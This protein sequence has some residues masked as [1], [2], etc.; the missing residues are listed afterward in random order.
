[1]L[2]AEYM[3][4]EEEGGESSRG[5]AAGGGGVRCEAFDKRFVRSQVGKM[6]S[7]HRRNQRADKES[8]QAD[9]F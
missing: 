2:G 8:M 3:S 1:M 6:Q 7:T 5:D 4:F 9:C